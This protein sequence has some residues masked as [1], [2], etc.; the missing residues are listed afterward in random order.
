MASAGD[1][2]RMGFMKVIVSLICAVSFLVLPSCAPG[3][4]PT[5]AEKGVSGTVK[6][7]NEVGYFAR[8]VQGIRSFF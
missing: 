4:P 3:Q 8:N 7:V 1:C 2:A 6:G 5:A